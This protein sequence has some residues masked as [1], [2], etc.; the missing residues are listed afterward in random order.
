MINDQW[1]SLQSEILLGFSLREALKYRILL[2]FLLLLA[3]FSLFRFVSL[4]SAC[5]KFVFIAILVVSFR[6]EI[7]WVTLPPAWCRITVILHQ[8][9][10]IWGACQAWQCMVA[11]LADFKLVFVR[12]RDFVLPSD[13]DVIA[14]EP[15]T[16][17]KR[18]P[19]AWCEMES[20]PFMCSLRWSAVQYCITVLCNYC[21][22]NG[23]IKVSPTDL[24]PLKIS[25]VIYM[26][27]YVYYKLI[28]RSLDAICSI[29]SSQLTNDGNIYVRN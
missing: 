5:W 25:S 27:Y 4:R 1:A 7:S 2:A 26:L 6:S 18:H 15:W 23:R 20:N 3:I 10:D 14:L 9:V 17:D 8:G 28:L 21:V 11:D 12:N 13:F 19:L 16:L 29:L 22:I 24:V